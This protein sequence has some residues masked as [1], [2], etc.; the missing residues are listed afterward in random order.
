MSSN[1]SAIISSYVESLSY[2][3]LEF[4]YTRYKRDWAGAKAEIGSFLERNESIRELLTSASSHKEFNSFND[5][6]RQ[7][8]I[9]ISEKKGVQEK[10][11]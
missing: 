7:E 1:K 10:L 2:V 3:D 4:L 5:D 11:Y 6:I 9:R 8:V